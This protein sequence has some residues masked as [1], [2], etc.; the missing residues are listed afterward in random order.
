M[1]IAAVLIPARSIGCVEIGRA[2]F[3]RCFSEGS[4]ELV[5]QD[6]WYTEGGGFELATVIERFREKTEE[7]ISKGYAGMR[8]N[9]SS[10]WLQKAN[11]ITFG[12]YEKKLDDLIAGEK[13]I[14]VCSFAL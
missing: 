9:G 12:E 1:D 14:V 5:S 3:E 10:A 13:V 7:A 11:S 8:A 2:D 4:I 6:E